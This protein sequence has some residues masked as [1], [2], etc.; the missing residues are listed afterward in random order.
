MKLIDNIQ[1]MKE[2]DWQANS[3][4]GLEPSQLSSGS[5]KKANWIC[6]KG[7]KWKSTIH[8]RNSEGYGCPYCSNQKILPGY[9]D[10]ATTHPELLQ[11]WDYQKNTLKPSEVTARSNRKVWWKCTKGHSYKA[12][13]AHKTEGRG[14][15][16]CSNKKVLVG[17]NDL[18]TT[19]PALANEWHPTKNGSLKPTD[20]VAGSA[21]KI[22]WKCPKGHE[23]QAKVCGRSVLHNGCAKCKEG[24]QTSFPEQ[25][26]FYYIK[27]IFPDAINRYRDIFN[28]GMELDIFIPSKNIAIEYDGSFYHKKDKSLKREKIKYNI[29]RQHRIKLIRICAKDNA[30]VFNFTSDYTY[31]EPTLDDSDNTQ[32]LDKIIRELLY[33][34]ESDFGLNPRKRY[35]RYTGIFIRKISVDVNIE[36][37]RYQINAYRENAIFKKSLAQVRPDLSEEWDYKKNQG[38]TPEMFPVGSHTEVWWICKK[39]GTSYPKIIRTRNK[40]KITC[41]HCNIK[42]KSKQYTLYMRDKKTS[43]ILQTFNSVAEAAK[44]TG[45]CASNID[46]ACRGSRKTAGGYIWQKEYRNH[47]DKQVIE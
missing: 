7:H 16:Y 19:H 40:L 5:N 36:R 29:C 2:W 23:Y 37:D 31:I 18:A 22:W 8:G 28:N 30:D 17:Y 32:G 25:A 45:I 35:I 6:N 38:L 27:Q 11:D 10:L 21:R 14:C 44:K 9:N 41:P 47:Y 13:T 12:A 1:L 33:M 46:G 4:E 20:I 26:I 39:C 24:N 43:K 34:L 42:C 3:K 15:P